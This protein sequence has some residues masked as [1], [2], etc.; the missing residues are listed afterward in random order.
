MTTLYRDKEVEPFDDAPDWQRITVG[1]QGVTDEQKRIF[2]DVIADGLC[3]CL[4]DNPPK[5]LAGRKALIQAESDASY[6]AQRL[7]GRRWDLAVEIGIARLAG[8]PTGDLVA[9]MGVTS[10]QLEAAEAELRAMKEA[11]RAF[12]AKHVFPLLKP[13]SARSGP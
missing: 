1:N 5:W 3:A 13:L 7:R 8:K 10:R 11:R 6:T 12:D 4:R 9:D 2:D